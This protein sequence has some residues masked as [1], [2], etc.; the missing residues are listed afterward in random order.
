MKAILY[1]LIGIL[2]V[3]Q[4]MFTF[5]GGFPEFAVLLSGLF[6]S[7]LMGA[8]Y[9]GLPLGLV[10]IVVGRLDARKREKV[11]RKL[12]G[13]SLLCGFILVVVGEAGAFNDL[14]QL[15]SVELVL[16]TISLSGIVASAAIGTM[17]AK[18]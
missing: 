18:R 6:A 11:L 14:L 5:A 16:S 1:P 13:L 7:T 17:R 2:F 12:L 15:S 4:A 3:S 10:R 8:F 9:V